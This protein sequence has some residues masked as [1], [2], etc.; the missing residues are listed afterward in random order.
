M[1]S[2][3]AVR[4]PATLAAIAVIAAVA[5]CANA[6]SGGP[7]RRA[8]GTGT[9]VQAYVQPLPPPPP[10]S[11]KKWTPQAVV[12]GFLHAS[13]SYAFDPAAAEQYL[14]PNL[15]KSWDPAIGPVAVVASSPRV[16]SGPLYNK[17]QFEGTASGTPF[18]NVTLRGQRLA[19]LSQTGQYQYTPGVNVEY[20]FV[21]ANVDGVW[22]IDGLPLGQPGLLLT[23][24]DFQSVYQARNLFFYAPASWAAVGVLLVPDP[25]YAPLESS[26]SALNTSLATGL[27]R[28][29]LKGPGIWLS[30]AASSAFPRGTRLLNQVTISGR[31]AKVDLGGAA[32]H[33]TD[34]QIQDM[35]AELQATLA[36]GSY[37][38]PL[39][40]KV[41]LYINN[42]QQYAQPL[43]DTNLVTPVSTG[44]VPVLVVTG[45]GSVGQL[46]DD[47]KANAH[48]VA[49]IGPAQFGG[50]P[51]TAIAAEPGHG[52][53]P[54]IAV[55]VQDQAGCAI[56][57][58]ASGQTSHAPYVL[59]TSG[60]AC[61]SLSWDNGGNLWAAAGRDVW[62]LRAQNRQPLAVD[63]GALTGNGQLGSPISQILAL[64][65]A[66]DGVRAA[67]LVHTRSSGNKLLLAAARFGR[68]SATFGQPVGIGAWPGPGAADPIAFSWLDAYHLAVLTD[69][70]VIYDV[71]LT[72]GTGVQPGGSPQQQLV[73]AAPDGAQTLTTDGSELVVG[74]L[75]NGGSRIF[76]SSLADPAW[77][78]VAPGSDPVYPG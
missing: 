16:N 51:I 26:N 4:L 54:P 60:G 2:G 38:A 15:R 11:A 40:S 37:S 56:Y 57:V 53:T 42:T 7:P 6:P 24:S 1:A 48:T 28:G 63:V 13:A 69:N 21:L 34:A 64:R 36:D 74:A 33:A 31:V 70:D 39:A 52:R 45:P 22:L 29:L 65:M 46:P 72:G 59:G 41:Q 67:L 10:T 78:S 44:P 32:A 62:V 19:T 68:G 8:T 73:G 61:T 14:V 25:V 76:A 71:P 66:P 23:E 49:R 3:R 55:A 18:E 9:Q 50:M 17:P 5:G 30:G 27:V 20:Q 75:Q 12:L 47:P 58:T 35:E 43:A 77:A